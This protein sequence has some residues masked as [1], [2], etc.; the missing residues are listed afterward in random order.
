MPDQILIKH[1]S[2]SEEIK[3]IKGLKKLQL[4]NRRWK[5]NDKLNI[6]AYNMKTYLTAFAE[7]SVLI[8]SEYFLLNLNSL[9]QITMRDLLI[10]QDYCVSN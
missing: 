5:W 10:N 1:S 2:H 7:N 6:T 8:K 3:L 4:V 9:Q